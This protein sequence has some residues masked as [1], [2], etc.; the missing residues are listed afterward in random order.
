MGRFTQRPLSAHPRREE[1]RASP[2]RAVKGVVLV[3]TSL[4]EGRSTIL[5]R[6]DD[7]GVDET[8]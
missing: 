4:G 8:E 6:R 7:D 1:L 2:L 3:L 5:V